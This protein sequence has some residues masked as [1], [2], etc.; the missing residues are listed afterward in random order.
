MREPYSYQNGGDWSWFG[1]RMVEALVQQGD[2]ADAY[3]KLQPMVERVKRTGGFHEWTRG[4]QPRRWKPG[5]ISTDGSL[6]IQMAQQNKL[7][8]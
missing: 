6:T 3:R 2:I 8:G 1:G 7:K 5:R 4:N